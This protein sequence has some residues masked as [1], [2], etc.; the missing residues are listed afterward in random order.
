[1]SKCV[2]LIGLVTVMA[3]A[4]SARAQEGEWQYKL[5]P[6]LWAMGID[7]D[8]G[9]RNATIP[10]DVKFS[11]AVKDMDVG[12]MLAMEANNGTWGVLLDGS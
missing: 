7:G 1:M 11:D 4:L 2:K 12:G 3:S 6:Y 9:V 10:V 5:T 8:I